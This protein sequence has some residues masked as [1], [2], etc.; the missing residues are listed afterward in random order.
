MRSIAFLI[1]FFIATFSWA[2][3]HHPDLK[4]F[5]ISELKPSIYMLQGKGGNIL[6][7]K[8]EQ[9]LL[10]VDN[11]YADNSTLLNKTLDGLGNTRYVINTHWHGDHTGGN[12]LLG[13]KSTIVAHDNVRKRLASP[14]KIALFG[15]QADTQPE[16]ALPQITYDKNLSLHFADQHIKTSHYASGHTDGDSIIFI[17][18]ANVVHMGDHYFNGIFPFVDVEN[19]GNVKG[20]AKN[21]AAVLK[22]IAH[23]TI[24]VPGH[25]PV[26]NKKELKA[27]L[28]MLNGTTDFIEKQLH[29]G[30]TL[31]QIQEE[32]L[33]KQWKSWGNGFLNE[34]TWIS[35]VVS[36]LK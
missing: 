1:S 27:F 35:I 36:S 2:E 14:Q 13:A 4:E 11:D 26:S 31:K 25:G 23:D 24:V 15:M 33:P 21:V 28:D 5:K 7:L 22:L 19:G 3:H 8:G 32:G 34:A 29:K 17:E 18:P 9:G 6:V 16:V 30:L 12:K 20:M 10:V